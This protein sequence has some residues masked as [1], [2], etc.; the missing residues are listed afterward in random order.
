ML[1]GRAYQLTLPRKR[2]AAGALFLD[3][4]QGILIVKPTYRDRWLIP[5]GVVEEGESPA[6]AC[7]REVREEL[8]LDV[9]L[10]RLLCLEY[11]SPTEDRTESLQFVFHGGVLAADQIAAIVVA[12]DE[13]SEYEFAQ[14]EEAV[15]KLVPRLATRVCLALSALERGVTIYAENGVEV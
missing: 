9:C 10:G 7:A 15:L 12:R 2:M 4:A 6:A 13:L 5:G 14:Q 11:Q 8:G 1:S 3:D